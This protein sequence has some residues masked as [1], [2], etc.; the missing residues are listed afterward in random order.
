M[1]I[2]GSNKIKHLTYVLVSQI[3]KTMKFQNC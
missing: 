3:K 2:D 1:I